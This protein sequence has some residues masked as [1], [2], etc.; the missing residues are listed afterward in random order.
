MT[1]VL[2][3]TSE[4]ASKSAAQQTG[5]MKHL[6]V[7][8][9]SNAHDGGIA[10]IILEYLVNREVTPQEKFP[11]IE[12]GQLN[13]AEHI[14]DLKAG[15]LKAIYHTDSNGDQNGPAP[16]KLPQSDLE[17]ALVVFLDS[18][19]YDGMVDRENRIVTPHESTFHWVLQDSSSSEEQNQNVKWSNLRE[20]LESDDQIY[21]ITG[22]AGSGKSTLMKY[23]SSPETGPDN[24]DRTREHSKIP[25]FKRRD[26]CHSFLKKWSGTKLL[27]VASF[28]FWNS[29]MELQM[30]QDGLL[31]TLLY[32]MVEQRPEILSSIIS[33]KQWEALCLFHVVQDRWSTLNLHS[34]LPK[35]VKALNDESKMCFFIDG[36]DEF[37]GDHELLIDMVKHIVQDNENLKICVASR[38]W[39][40]FQ[41]A[42]G[43]QPNLRLEDLTFNDIRS[44][45]QSKF[46]ANKD[47]ELLQQRYP[48][49]AGDSME[50]V[51]KKAAGVFLWV[52]LVVA[53]LLAGMR[54]GDRIQ[55]F[56]RRLDELPPDL[57]SLYEK[58]LHSFESFYLEHAAQHFA[59][60]EC[61]KEPI[62]MIQF[63]FADEETPRSA[64]GMKLES[65]KSSERHARAE[66]VKR[67]LN[68]RCK[69]LLETDRILCGAPTVDTGIVTVQ[70]LHR[71]VKDFIN[72][73]KAQ[74]FL[75][76]S[77]SPDFDPA[78][79]LCLAYLMDLKTWKKPSK[80]EPTATQA[81][82]SKC[83][84]CIE[85][86]AAIQEKNEGD[87][88]ELLDEL[89]SV[90]KQ[91]NF[92]DTIALGL[93]RLNPQ[94]DLKAYMGG[95]HPTHFT[96]FMIWTYDD[97]ELLLSLAV[98]YNVTA[99][100]RARAERGGLIRHK[101][102]PEKQWPLLR[103][104]VSNEVPDPEMVKC[105]LDLGADP[106]FV[107]S[108]FDSQ[109]P[110]VVALTK[111][112]I[113]YTI[114]AEAE[115]FEE[116]LIAEEKWKQTLR[117][118]YS[119]GASSTM[120][121]ASRLSPISR[122]IFQEVTG[123]V[124][125]KPQGEEGWLRSL[126]S[127]LGFYLGRGEK[128]LPEDREVRIYLGR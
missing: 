121:P 48:L 96:F 61:A 117:L 17:M 10:A 108:K 120:I 57:E 119:H 28:Y 95:R 46:Q 36:L 66:A 128:P 15:L 58:I 88:V 123:G 2:I 67:R 59:L 94:G 73:F 65:L 3:L 89:K 56:Q 106:N 5:I 83:F 22:K 112:T 38:P 110:W 9:D 4:Y 104:A 47:F 115:N 26:R 107:V 122:K 62:N 7:V 63:S 78:L 41:D 19:Q 14:R 12:S 81:W 75:K 27:V 64:I 125:F 76:S 21:W 42:L 113:L 93:D 102:S 101:Y 98:T 43:Q 126:T 33:P 84:R 37:G 34:M 31:R 114:R 100:V 109:S 103:S 70:Y 32:Q 85:T 91:S 80:M 124:Q 116:Y 18:L 82:I 68:S 52:D 53:S 99:Y 20:W 127:S 30:T 90:I 50:N 16:I 35:A 111:V 24:G 23:L 105:L 1:S 39:N 45:V 69:G 87:L 77:L 79:Q 74:Q 118:M 6:D 55:D 54:Y 51:V 13:R 97:N 40:I 8:R 29:G 86:A 92:T 71:T 11:D 49:F 25:S 72:S 44:F 60:V